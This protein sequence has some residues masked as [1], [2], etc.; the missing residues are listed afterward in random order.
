MSRDL[1]LLGDWGRATEPTPARVRDV[2]DR[3]RAR[4]CLASPAEEALHA[5]P[6][7]TPQALAR[8]GHAFAHRLA[9]RPAARRLAVVAAV[10]AAA[11]GVLAV[12]LLLPRADRVLSERLESP[13]TWRERSPTTDV[14]LRFQG[15]GSLA[16]TAHAPEITWDNGRLEVDVAPEREI[17]LVVLTREARVAVTGTSFLVDRS[18]LGSDVS[19]DTGT[20][21]VTCGAGAPRPLAAGHR[22][23]CPPVSASGWLGR[24]NALL[25]R[26]DAPGTLASAEAGLA[27]G[28]ALPAVAE[29]LA[30]IRI[31]ALVVLDRRAEALEAAEAYLALGHPMREVEIRRTAARLALA[32]GGCARALPHLDA[33]AA[34]DPEAAA[35]LAT[36][37]RREAP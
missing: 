13:G 7:P 9:P 14:A 17:R 25:D 11:A 34:G 24:A 29:E 35:L 30:A 20:V 4:G 18:A 12:A 27:L 31:L 23:T 1:V 32:A 15:S 22:Y 33:L 26:G 3:L 16:G 8:A 28:D 5:L 6:A 21:Q 36:C 19:V 10:A 37:S 2:L